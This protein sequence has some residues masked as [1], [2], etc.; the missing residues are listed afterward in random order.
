MAP[1]RSGWVLCTR[2]PAAATHACCGNFVAPR[3]AP[4]QVV[5]GRCTGLEAVAVGE[6]GEELSLFSQP[7]F[8]TIQDLRAMDCDR[9]PGSQQL[10]SYTTG[11]RSRPSPPRSPF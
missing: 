4:A 10:V 7:V 1:P 8:G 9:L 2:R 5:L 3:P 11:Q 6:D